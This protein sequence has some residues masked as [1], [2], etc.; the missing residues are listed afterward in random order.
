MFGPTF[1]LKGQ[2]ETYNFLN[3]FYKEPKKILLPI[4]DSHPDLIV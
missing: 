3:Q 2:N 4:P 1:V